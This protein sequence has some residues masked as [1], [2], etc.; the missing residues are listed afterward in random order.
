MEP[1]PISYNF[2]DIIELHFSIKEKVD[3][4]PG[5]KCRFDVVEEEVKGVPQAIQLVS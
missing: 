3:N 5:D 2:G 4:V 1:C